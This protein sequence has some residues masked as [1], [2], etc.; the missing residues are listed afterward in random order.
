MPKVKIGP[1]TFDVPLPRGMSSFALQQRVAPIA[2]RIVEVLASFLAIDSLPTKED[3][4]IDLEAIDVGDVLPKVL[5][6]IGS[7]FSSLPAGELEAVTRALLADAKVVGIPG[8][9]QGIALFASTPLGSAGADYFDEVMQG[10]AID[11]WRLLWEAIK[12]WYPDFFVL[13]GRS[14]G[15]TPTPASPSSE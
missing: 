6:A 1:T 7:A 3:G 4:T 8:A 14:R 12:I 9:P 2:T 13:A 10:R 5:P 15:R 11:T